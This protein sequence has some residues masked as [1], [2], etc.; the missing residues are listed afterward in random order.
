MPRTLCH[1]DAFRRNLF[2]GQDQTVAIDW[3][4]VGTGAVSEDI[5][6][7]VGITLQFMNL[8]TA[9]LGELEKRVVDGYLTGLR[10]A[11]WHGDERIVRF[12]YTASAALF[13]GVATVGC[14]PSVAHESRYK[15][16]ENAIGHPIDTVIANFGAL[17]DHFLDLGDEALEMLGVL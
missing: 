1:H 16:A 11:G 12:G 4:I 2:A 14:W 15:I 17:Q 7:L 10:D 8:A 13:I 3:Q 6:P 9:K 5:V